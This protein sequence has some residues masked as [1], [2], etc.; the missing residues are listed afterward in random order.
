MDILRQMFGNYC[1]NVALISWLSAQVLKTIFTFIATKKLN[2]ERMVGA[3][4]M[5]SAHSALVC[6]L[7][8][9]IARTVGVSSP[10]FALAFLVA[11]VVMYDA[12]GVRRSAGEQAKVLNKII[13]TWEKSQDAPDEDEDDMFKKDLKESLGHTP[14]EVLG[15]ALLGILVAMLVS[16]T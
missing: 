16:L 15:G 14:L 12:M 2:L 3:G 10:E 1:L 4:G 8:V 5:P 13:F 6:S 11:C 7:T 9:A